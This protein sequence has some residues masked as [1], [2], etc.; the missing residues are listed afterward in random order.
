MC[1]RDRIGIEVASLGVQVHGGMGFIEETG[2]CQHLRDSRIT[3]I[4][5]GTTGIQAADLA[6]RK[7]NMDKGAA[8]QALIVDMET[9]VGALGQAAG[10]DLA[11]IRAALVDGVKALVGA[12]EWILNSRDPNACLLYTSRCV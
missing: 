8:M 2:A 12:T 9:T 6:G 10:D 3:T 1:I 7:L 5:E 11:T 4:Y